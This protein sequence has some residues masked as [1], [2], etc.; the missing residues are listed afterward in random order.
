[1]HATGMCFYVVVVFITILS[2]DYCQ[3]LSV[4]VSY[5]LF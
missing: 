1:M 5:W 4:I 2:L 3:L